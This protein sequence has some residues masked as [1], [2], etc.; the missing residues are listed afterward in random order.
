[1]RRLFVRGRVALLLEAGVHHPKLRAQ[2]VERALLL[3]HDLAQL[4]DLT[5][6]VRCSFWMSIA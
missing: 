5:F 4:R 6:E 3:E 1:V 2:S